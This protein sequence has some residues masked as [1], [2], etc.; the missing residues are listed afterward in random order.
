MSPCASLLGALAAAG[1]ACAADPAELTV[2]GPDYPRAFFFRAAESAPARPGMTYEAWDGDFGRLMGIMGKCLG[3]ELSGRGTRN[4]EW[5]SRFKRSHPSQ[6]VMLHVNGNARDPRFCTERYFAGHWVYRAATEIAADV[7]AESGE[8]EIRVKDAGD[9]QTSAGRYRTS[10]DDVALFG[11]TAEGRHDW[12]H[13]EQVQVVSVDLRSNTLRVRRGCYGTRPMA[14]KAGQSRAAAHAVEGPWGKTDHLLWYYNYSAL[15][16]RDAE[17]KRCADRLVDD[18]GAWFGKGGALEAFDGVEFDVLFNETRG[19]T[20]GDGIADD[21]VIDG[22]NQYGIGLVAFARS[23]RERLGAQRIIQGD[24]ALG[25]GGVRSQRAFGLLNGIESEGWPN[26]DDWAL[27]D[28]SGGLNRMLFWKANAFPPAFSYINHKWV[29]PVPG[30]PGEHQNVSVPFARHRLVFAAAQFADAAVCCSTQPPQEPHGAAVIWD[31]FVCGAENRVGWLGK[32][33]GPT[34]CLAASAPD[35]LGGVGRPAGGALAGRIAG[36]VT[37]RATASGV[38]VTARDPA[39]QETVFTLRDIPAGIGDL[40]VFA[41]LQAVPRKGYPAEMAR[42]AA[43]EVSGGAL[44]LLERMPR[45]TGM[46]LRGEKERPIGADS[47]AR[48]AFQPNVR[49]GDA[50]L[51][52]Y[53][54]HPPFKGGAG[55]VFWF[56]DTQLPKDAE[57]RF[58]LGLSEKASQKSDGV[59]FSV[60]AAAC[61]GDSVGPY[62]KVFEA[63]SRAHGWLPHAVPLSKWGGRRVRIKFVADC[64]PRDNTTA[65]QGFWGD[66]KIVRAGTKESEL[67]PASSQ[68][69]WVNVRPFEAAFYFRDLRS[70]RVDLTFR[71]EGGEP[72]TL[73]AVSSHASPDARVRLFEHGV[74]L[75]NPG[76]TPFFFDLAA[77]APGRSFRRLCATPQQD[78]QANDGSPVGASVTLGPLEGLFLES[79]R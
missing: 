13:C 54:V 22:V 27:D 24:G 39:A 49:I 60:L 21:G 11:V 3:E 41:T 20:D 16:P 15:C 71:V 61:E 58:S 12:A 8:T 46:A 52:A 26:L 29:Q 73:Q 23:L 70:P 74:V 1:L 65:D 17:G 53:A 18:F 38:E 28:W 63:S 34:V 57:L 64:G 75:A 33:L 47:G 56:R 76:H 35:G 7:P 62:E 42:L 32:P 79:C 10:A 31:E 30:K 43:V 4:A 48:V 36:E 77:F 44:P 25:S 69:T 37:A 50:V 14:F 9:F 45:Q 72:V 51:P 6:L 19:D 78:L 55:Y 68:M 59:W 66:V 40:T 67:T 2:V 5:F